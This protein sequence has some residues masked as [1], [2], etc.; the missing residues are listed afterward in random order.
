MLRGRLGHV[1][2]ARRDPADAMIRKHEVLELTERLRELVEL[3]PGNNQIVHGKAKRV[4][5]TLQDAGFGP[6]VAGRC[7]E[8][9]ALFDQWFSGDRW[10]RRQDGESVQRDL[11]R[12]LA[13]L[14]TLIDDWYSSDDRRPMPYDEQ[15]D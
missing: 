8:L 4:L 3:G 15:A 2:T 5:V 1:K 12:Q 7:I 9:R 6:E 13:A 14:E 10:V 11:H